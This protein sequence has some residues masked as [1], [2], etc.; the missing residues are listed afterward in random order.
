[1]MKRTFPFLA[2]AI[3]VLSCSPRVEPVS[4]TL[5]PLYESEADALDEGCLQMG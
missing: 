5:I 1:M 4:G 3:V 2:I